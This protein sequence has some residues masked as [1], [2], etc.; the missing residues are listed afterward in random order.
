M[1]D[2]H[3]IDGSY[4]EE[5]EGSLYNESGICRDWKDKLGKVLTAAII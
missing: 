1:L 3:S 4:S 2:L 5:T